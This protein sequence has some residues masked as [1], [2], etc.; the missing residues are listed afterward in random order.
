MSRFQ[1]VINV[2][3]W[4]HAHQLR[5]C[6]AFG[7]AGKTINAFLTQDCRHDL[8]YK[9]SWNKQAHKQKLK[10]DTL[11]FYQLLSK[12]IFSVAI[13]ATILILSFLI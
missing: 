7:E 2:E 12:G 9:Q 5:L 6:I 13:R 1:V 11:S 4:D 8:A 3:Y 10:V